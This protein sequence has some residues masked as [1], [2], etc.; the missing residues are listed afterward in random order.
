MLCQWYIPP[1]CHIGTKLIFHLYHNN[2]PSFT[3]FQVFYL[4]CQFSQINFTG[5]KKWLV[6]GPYFQILIQLQPPWI[7]SK[8]P[9]CTGIRARTKD[10]KQPFFFCHFY[11]LPDISVFGCKIPFTRSSF[12]VIPE[13]IGCNSIQ[14]HGFD[15]L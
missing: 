15:H 2:R 8:F 10:Y 11:K 5:I 4:F 3:Y 1:L 6:I 14:T 13:Y 9:F 7:S 12:M